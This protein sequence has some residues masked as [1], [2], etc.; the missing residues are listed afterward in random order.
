MT[1]KRA[2]GIL[3]KFKD[4]VPSWPNIDWSMVYAELDEEKICVCALINADTSEARPFAISGKP[5][6]RS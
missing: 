3:E 5:W 2:R 1:A 4:G 6:T